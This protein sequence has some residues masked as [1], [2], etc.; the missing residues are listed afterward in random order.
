MT[1]WHSYKPY[2]HHVH[3]NWVTAIWGLIYSYVCRCSTDG[4][5][6]VYKRLNIY[7]VLFYGNKCYIILHLIQFHVPPQAGRSSGHYKFLAF[8]ISIM[9]STSFLFA[10][11]F[12]LITSSLLRLLPQL[13][14]GTRLE[15]QCHQLFVQMCPICLT[16]T[17]NAEF[18][19]GECRWNLQQIWMETGAAVA[20]RV[21][22]VVWWSE[23]RWFNS[24]LPWAELSCVSLSKIL[25]PK[26]LPMCSWQ[27]PPSVCECGKYCK[28]LW[29]VENAIYKCKSVFVILTVSALLSRLTFLVWL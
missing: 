12:T 29:E 25:N 10:Q 6:R 18:L 24:R 15:K 16:V 21:E 14:N 11:G 1:F 9:F 28:V 3:L 13:L 27:L 26:L 5:L 19:G 7:F 4:W 23:G 2:I 8:L 22:Q 20:Q 17:G